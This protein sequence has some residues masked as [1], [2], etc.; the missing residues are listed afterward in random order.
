MAATVKVA[1]AQTAAATRDEADT[2]SLHPYTLC[3][4]PWCNM[5]LNIK[6][7]EVERLAAEVARLNTTRN[8]TVHYQLL[9]K[10]QAGIGMDTGSFR[11]N[12]CSYQQE[13]QMI[14]HG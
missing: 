13:Q 6:N 3:D 10:I 4:I 14:Q 1:W 8:L 11:L 5:P 7:A 2:R 9:M 12:S